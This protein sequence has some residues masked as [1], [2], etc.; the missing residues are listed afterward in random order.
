MK[1][2]LAAAL[3]GLNQTLGMFSYKCGMMDGMDML[4]RTAS[5]YKLLEEWSKRSTRFVTRHG[6]KAVIDQN[7]DDE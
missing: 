6:F 2:Y 1:S 7:P 3:P 4:D 5:D